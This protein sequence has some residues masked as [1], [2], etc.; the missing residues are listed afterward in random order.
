MLTATVTLPADIENLSTIK[1]K[2]VTT[3]RGIVATNPDPLATLKAQLSQQDAKL[4][5]IAGAKLSLSSRLLP[6]ARILC[7]CACACVS[8]CCE[9]L[10]AAGQMQQV[11]ELLTAK[12]AV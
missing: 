8:D 9:L 3:G 2:K 5:Q 6:L 7:V 10:V 4:E 12:N 11:M 1:A